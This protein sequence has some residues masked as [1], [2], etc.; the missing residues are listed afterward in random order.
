MKKL[1]SDLPPALPNP[2]QKPPRKKRV[3][4]NKPHQWGSAAGSPRGQPSWMNQI[5]GHGRVCRVCGVEE[6]SGHIL[7]DHS[8][9]GSEGDKLGDKNNRVQLYTYRDAKNHTFTSKKPL[10][11]PVFILDHMGTTMENREMLR[12]VDDRVDHTDDRV[13]SVEARLERLE[14]ENAVLRA[15][16]EERVDVGAM[17]EWLASMV[18]LHAAQNMEMVDVMVEGRKVAA[19]PPPVANLIIDV[20]VLTEK[21]PVKK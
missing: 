13:D 4:A 16:L 18:G 7:A 19:L 17:V 10:G 12:E 21:V 9:F 15:K 8:G 3:E 5:N 11:C 14:A 6:V 1:L 20:G 2:E